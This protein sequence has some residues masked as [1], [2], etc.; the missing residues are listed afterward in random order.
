MVHIL[1]LMLLRL[2]TPSAKPKKR[3]APGDTGSPKAKKAK[4][5]PKEAANGAKPKKKRAKKDPNAPK[6][7]TS[8]LFQSKIPMRTAMSHIRHLFVA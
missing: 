8:F 7:V 5:A 6:K 3:P 4:A 1:G 2:Q